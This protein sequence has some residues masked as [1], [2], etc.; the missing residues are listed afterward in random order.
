VGMEGAGFGGV[1]SVMAR[2]AKQ[3]AGKRLSDK[4]R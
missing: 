3:N 1:K 4:S 2:L